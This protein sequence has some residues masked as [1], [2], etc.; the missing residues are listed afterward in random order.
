ME[1]LIVV[2]AA[3]MVVSTTLNTMILRKRQ[4]YIQKWKEGSLSEAQLICLK[5]QYWFRQRYMKP[6][7]ESV[8]PEKK[9]K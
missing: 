5:K 8:P 2:T 7:K 6:V 1:T 9:E 3:N 4:E